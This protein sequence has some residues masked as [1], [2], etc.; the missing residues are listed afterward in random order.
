MDFSLTSVRTLL[1]RTPAVLDVWL[2]GLAEEWTRCNEGGETWS[3][4][5]IVGHL[6]HGETT[7]WVPR[8]EHLLRHGESVPFPPFDRFAQFR[9]SQGKTLT[10]LLGEFRAARG[11]S[12]R[13]LAAMELGDVELSR[14]GTHPTL[15]RV[16]LSELLATWV[17]HDLDHLAQIARVM[18]RQYH[19]AVGPWRQFLRIMP[20]EK[21]D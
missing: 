2:T 18:A 21:P 8:I 10:D 5:D 20:R 6:I 4:F 1:E 17:A 12:L 9:E 16:R 3:V 15:G 14:T 13:R 11:E 7:D 19:D